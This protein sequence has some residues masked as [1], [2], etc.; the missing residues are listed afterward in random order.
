MTYRSV[1][2]SWF[3]LLFPLAWGKGILLISS[4][5]NNF[6]S[7]LRDLG[8]PFS[9]SSSLNALNDLPNTM[10]SFFAHSTIQSP[11]Y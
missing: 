3:F 4:E 2:L 8:I 10:P 6:A 5:E 11:I 1:F 9:K 7:L